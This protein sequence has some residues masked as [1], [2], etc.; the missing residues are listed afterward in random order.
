[1]KKWKFGVYLRL[2]ADEK[3]KDNEQSNSVVNQRNIIGYYLNDKK[4]I[5]IFKCYVDDG[6]TGTDF[7]RPGYKEMLS[8][9]KS[10]KINGVIVKD[11][12]RLGRNYIQ[13]GNFIDKIVPSFKLRFISVNDHVD[14]LN[15]PHLMDSLE[16]PF[17]NLINENYSKDSSIKLRTALSASKKAGNFIGKYAPY[18]YIKD[19]NDC[20]KLNIDE[21]AAK[22]V[23]NIFELVLK[24]KS[25]Q[26][27][28][29]ELNNN[30]ILT[31]SIYM[32]ERLGAD[33]CNPS[34]K[35]TIKM[36]DNILTNETYIGNLV[37]GKRTRLNH[38]AHNFVRVAE[39]EWVISKNHHEPIIREDL[40]YQVQDILYGRNIRINN[41]GIYNK[42]VGF[43]KCSECGNNLYRMT[44]KKRGTTQVFYYC[45]TYIK[46]KQCNKHYMLESKIDK[47]VLEAIN[48]H[49]ELI[50]DVDRRID[51]TISYSRIDYDKEVKKLKIIEINKE[52]SQYESFLNDLIK[53][54]QCDIISQED[55]EE[56][57]ND[58]LYETNRLK[59][60]KENLES[61]K[62]TLNNLDWI[63]KF[64]K[65]K[66]F[67]DIN[68][69]IINDFIKNIYVGDNND[70]E[71]SFLYEDQYEDA[72]KYLKS[73]N[74]VV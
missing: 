40:F 72:L 7:N 39:G 15:N 23:K 62:F 25:K 63:K 71:I 67:T 45:G 48:Q 70:I 22:V 55:F 12:S 13:V 65:N 14:S 31:P 27:I 17:K 56:F 49:L 42:Y 59:L 52:I 43:L 66:K 68:R 19:E 53:D 46:T 34:K 26:E 21:E 51:E 38:K 28:V 61:S 6:Y 47:V 69:S 60:E 11:L 74:N 73:K 30:H 20:H 58:Y 4:D 44:R 16:I 29:D 57:K 35:W 18:G 8:D 3:G 64:K 1:M 54:Y 32:K 50:C 9:I 10:K 33:I 5:K 2:S 41:N 36:I 37:Q 24:G